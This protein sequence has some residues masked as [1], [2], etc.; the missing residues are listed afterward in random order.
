LIFRKLSHLV[1][2]IYQKVKFGT[3]LAPKKEWKRKDGGMKMR[4]FFFRLI[5]LSGWILVLGGCADEVYIVRPDHTPP[6]RPKGLYSVTADEAVYLFWE[7]NDEDD[8]REYRVYRR[9]EGDDYYH[10]IGITK[11]AEYVDQN[12][13]NGVTYFYAVTARDKNGN[14]SD[15]SDVVFDTPRPEGW[16]WSLYDRFYKP[17]RSG[18]DFSE[19]AILYW[20][21]YEADIYLEYDDDLESFFLCVANDQ[22][23]IQDFGYTDKLDD[24]DYSPEK[25]WSYVGWVEV[26]PGH[27]YIIWTADNHFAKLRVKK[28]TGDLKIDFDWAYQVDPGNPEL[29]PRPPHGK[30]YLRVE[31]EK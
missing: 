21:D 12:V 23:D 31:R 7:E 24:V 10:R 25:G 27:S 22:T 4:K 9:E 14:E 1:E 13:E 30:D 20:D 8:F 29:A 19:P 2:V 6:S 17:S 18:F 28:I 16:G 3:G 5:L 26:I 15:F 11:I